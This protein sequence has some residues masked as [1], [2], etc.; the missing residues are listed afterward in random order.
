MKEAKMVKGLT[1][2]INTSVVLPPGIHERLKNSDRGVSEELRDRV[3]RTFAD[4]G[5]DERTR[6]LRDAVVY[7]ADQLSKEMGAAWHSS[8]K[9]H[10]E[11]VAGIT[12]HLER[13]RPAAEP[14]GQPEPQTSEIFD[15]DEPP[16]TIGRLRE[17]DFVLSLPAERQSHLARLELLRAKTRKGQGGGDEQ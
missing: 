15:L 7:L 2:G 17:R 8:P 3:E 10:Q 11:L 13:Q 4:E 14:A 1:R 16:G 9:V 5:L 6:L 12:R